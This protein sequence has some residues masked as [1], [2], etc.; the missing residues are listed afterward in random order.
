MPSQ[1]KPERSVTGA[2]PAGAVLEWRVHLARERPRA[3]LFVAGVLCASA[4]LAYA[5]FGHP[6]P[7]LITLALLFSS[8]SEFVLPITYRIAPEGITRRNGVNI[9]T[10]AWDEVRRMEVY[11]EGVRLSPLARPSALE[12][13]RGILIRYPADS[14]MRQ[15]MLDALRVYSRE[16]DPR[17]EANAKG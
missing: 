15:R 7:V 11:E 16:A 10:L 9:T 1:T 8:V 12:P 6:L 17:G 13:F 5:V 2:H 4:A 14:G 3:L